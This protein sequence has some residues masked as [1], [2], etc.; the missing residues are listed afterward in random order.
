MM[1]RTK[2]VSITGS[3]GCGAS[4]P[5]VEGVV[6]RVPSVSSSDDREDSQVEDQACDVFLTT[7]ENSME[8]DATLVLTE[9]RRG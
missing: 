7:G 5:S 3:G 2:L 1:E 9:G 8:S 4:R 6:K